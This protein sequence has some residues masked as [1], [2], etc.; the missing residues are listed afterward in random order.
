MGNICV[1]QN[2]SLRVNQ[3]TGKRTLNDIH[4]YQGMAAEART[5]ELTRF[6]PEQKRRERERER[7]REKL[8]G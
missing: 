3:T 1:C 2:Q 8:V 4:I 5:V 7:E 6:K